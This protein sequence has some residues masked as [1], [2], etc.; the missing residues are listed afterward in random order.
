[1]QQQSRIKAS[2]NCVNISFKCNRMELS[3]YVM[4]CLSCLLTKAKQFTSSKIDETS[5][6]WRWARTVTFASA[7]QPAQRGEVIVRLDKA[8][9]LSPPLGHFLWLKPFVRPKHG[10]RRRNSYVFSLRRCWLMVAEAEGPYPAPSL[11]E[12]FTCWESIL[13]REVCSAAWRDI[14]GRYVTTE[15]AEPAPE[16]RT[17]K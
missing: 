16:S 12:H 10:S 11:I 9:A 6:L 13:N 15:N 5:L 14:S 4:Q 8:L 17:A 1:M 3:W 2:A 7:K